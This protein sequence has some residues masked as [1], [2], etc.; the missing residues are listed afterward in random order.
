MDMFIGIAINLSMPAVCLMSHPPPKTNLEHRWSLGPPQS[1]WDHLPWQWDLHG[2]QTHRWRRPGVEQVT[3]NCRFVWKTSSNSDK[4]RT[5]VTPLKTLSCCS[6]DLPK[7]S[8]ELKA[9][10]LMC[11]GPCKTSIAG[12]ERAG[13]LWLKPGWKKSCGIRWSHVRRIRLDWKWVYHDLS[14]IIF[15]RSYAVPIQLHNL[16]INVHIP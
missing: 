2:R 9:T 6:S 8:S 13:L 1:S 10:C 11:F 14:F 12:E 15:D 4:N 5:T 16:F 7:A 3:N